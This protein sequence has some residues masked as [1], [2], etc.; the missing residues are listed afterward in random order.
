[1]V[2]LPQI[3][4]EDGDL[5]AISKPAGLLAIPDGY[6]PALPCV[7]Q[8]IQSTYGRVWVVHRLDKET[9]GIMLLARSP[10]AHRELN[11]QFERRQVEKNYQAIIH[12]LPESDQFSADLPLRVNGDRRHRTLI[13]RRQGKPARTDFQVLQ[14][15][16]RFSLI[17]ARPHT[18]YT[19]QIRAHLA[20]LGFPILSDPLYQSHPL[21]MNSPIL[22]NR[23]ALHAMSIKFIHP[24]TKICMELFAPPDPDFTAA[25][26][27][28]ANEK[29]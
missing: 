21:E 20:A 26:A 2:L 24:N 1:M 12:G 19:H 25:L 3:I 9:S 13:D 29:N 28:L 22:I 6:Q 8:L 11:L 18:G 4:Y 7:V 17:E 5:L 10:A 16:D 14:R 23:V 27:A 15:F